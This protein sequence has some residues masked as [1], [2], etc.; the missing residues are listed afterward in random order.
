MHFIVRLLNPPASE[1]LLTALNELATQGAPSLQVHVDSFDIFR[2][3]GNNITE[4]ESLQH[5]FS[6]RPPFAL[7]VSPV[8]VSFTETIRTSVE[9]EGR[10]IRQT[11]GVG[12]SGHCEIR[13]EPNR[14]GAGYAFHNGMPD[15]AIPQAYI[16]SIDKGIQQA[17]RQGILAGNPVVDVKVTLYNAS[18]HESDSN[19]TAFERA[20]ASAFREALGNAAPVLLEPVMAL[21][22]VVPDERTSE[23][24]RQI[25]LHRGRIETSNKLF[26]ESEIYAIVPLAELLSSPVFVSAQIQPMFAG[27]EAVPDHE[28]DDTSGVTATRPRHPRPHVRSQSAIPEEE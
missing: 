3:S 1:P 26:G 21:R 15:G 8:R 23:V 9:A 11:G 10:Y 6:D 5:R 16:H 19:S 18:H 4:L 14:R 12:N 25:Q 28:G 24:H 22:L 13:I 7:D 2:I 27:Y 20:A 17:M